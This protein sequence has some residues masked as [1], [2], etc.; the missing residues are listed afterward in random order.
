MSHTHFKLAKKAHL[1]IYSTQAMPKT[2]PRRKK[3]PTV[4]NL[5]LLRLIPRHPASISTVQLR[6]A[7]LQEDPEF[8][9]SLRSL[10]RDLDALLSSR[11]NFNLQCS[12]DDP[13][14]RINKQRPFLWSYTAHARPGLP[15]MTSAEALAMRLSEGH[16]QHL[17]PPN[18]LTLLEPHFSEARAVLGHN[19]SKAH[20]RW[21]QRVRSLPNGKALLPASVDK[22][23]WEKVAE[24]LLNQKQIKV[25]Y[26]SKKK[27]EVTTMTLHPKGMV[28]RGPSTYLIASAGSYIEPHHFVLQRFKNIEVLDAASRDDGFDMDSYLPTAAFTPR[29]GS[30]TLQLLAEIHP[31]IAWILRETPLSEGQNIT[32]KSGC[33]WLHLEAEVPDDEETCWWVLSLGRNII[34]REPESLA[35]RIKS[36][37]TQI[38]S[39]Y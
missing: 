29:Q 21:A 27:G 26:L 17:L 20:E 2:N 34:V 39:H 22:D 19:R 10:Q 4:R 38:L 14:E 6:D 11:F 8:D 37:A 32:A 13:D 31:D 36:E 5:L 24:A 3:D 23:I 16:L 25:E 12:R 18:V 15:L 7:L 35:S 1:H 30:G 28:S 33:N 9:I